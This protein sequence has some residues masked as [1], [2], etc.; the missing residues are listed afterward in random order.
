MEIYKISGRQLFWLFVIGVLG[1]NILFLPGLAAESAG[2]D[3]WMTPVLSTF[4]GLG[5]IWVAVGLAGRFPGKTLID[6]L[7]KVFGR[8]PGKFLGLLY[9][10]F[11]FYLTGLIVR[12]STTFITTAI[13]T[14]TPP[15]V[16]TTM[17]LLP[18]A[19]AVSKGSE[20]IARVN[21]WVFM[22]II[23]SIFL[24]VSLVLKEG[25][26][27][28]ITPIL[29]RGIV[30][31]LKGSLAPTAFRAEVALMILMLA[32]ALNKQKELAWR[33]VQ[34]VLLIGLVMVATTL[35][36][37]FVFEEHEA[38]R[39]VFPTYE[40]ARMISVGEFLER[41]DPV[42]LITWISGTFV[43][44]SI[45]YYIS[46]VAGTQVFGLSTYRPLI[47]PAGIMFISLSSLEFT[48]LLKM[49]SFLAQ[50]WPFLGLTFEFI[51][52]LAVLTA[53][54]LRGLGGRGRKEN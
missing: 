45:F 4:S 41:F 5:I 47:I 49:R 32:P 43:K 46:V 13:L 44:I 12:E 24:I 38:A 22:I 54:W 15:V 7:P 3:A 28:N 30:P 21:E 34:A 48:S 14:K 53:A 29:D 25:D 37:S 19:Y 20:V 42:V 6:Y 40:L 31:V 26:I 17:L 18:V 11:F 27:N 16:I 39:I 23:F 36:N 50:T 51:L 9:L 52:P 35:A 33:S 10:C 8:L 1:T 2:K